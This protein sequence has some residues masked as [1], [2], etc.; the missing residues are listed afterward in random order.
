MRRTIFLFSGILILFFA[1]LLN[2]QIK[3]T[4]NFKA[5]RILKGYTLHEGN[6]ERTFVM[7]LRFLKSYETPPDVILSITSIDA[8]SNSGDEKK[9]E[10]KYDIKTDSITTEGFKIK[11]KVWGNTQLHHIIGNWLAIKK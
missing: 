6:G 3:E 5:N 2:A 7:D 11:M 4:G 9:Y 1:V 8:E 10:L